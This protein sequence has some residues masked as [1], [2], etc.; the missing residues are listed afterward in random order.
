VQL[1]LTPKEGFT[2]ILTV[3]LKGATSEEERAPQ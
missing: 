3:I 1:D 2:A